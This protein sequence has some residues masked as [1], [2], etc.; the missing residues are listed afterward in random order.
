MSPTSILGLTITSLTEQFRSGR[1]SPVD[2]IQVVLDQIRRMEPQIGAFVVRANEDDLLRQA[3]QAAARWAAGIP[4]GPLDGVPMVIKDAIL[5]KGWPNRL[6]SRVTSAAV[7]EEDAPAVA[8]AREAGALFLGKTTTPEFG[9]KGVTDSPLSGIT[10]NPWDPRLTP[11]GSSGGAA[12]AVAA[13]MGYGA[14]GTDAA[15]SVRIPAAFTGL[16]GLKATRGRIAAYP[17]S[18]LWTL[19]HIGP[20]TR[21]TRDAALMLRVMGRA[22]ARDWNSLPDEEVDYP[23][24]LG[25]SPV[26]G[27]KIAYSP[28]LGHAR[29]DTH[30]AAAVRRVA[31]TLADMGAQVSEVDTPLPD[32]R[33]HFRVYFA[34]GLCHSL[35][36][37]NKAERQR[38]DP[39]LLAL[40]ERHASDTR[41]QFLQAYDFQIRL[42]REA[43]LFHT[44]YDFLLTPTM[45]TPPFQAG[46]AAPEGYDE[47]NWLDWSPFTYPFNLTGQPAL[48]LPCGQTPEG[49]PLAAQFVGALYDDARLLA[50]AHAVEQAQWRQPSLA[51]CLH[52]L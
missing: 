42:A 36:L 15:G 12:A 25:R 37:L 51:P 46:A 41:E 16:V 44:R 14:I 26:V 52:S 5:C 27:L 13:G 40:L 30:V 18:A 22:D 28:T 21:D 17:P 50:L 34:A 45:A 10:R 38:L 23:E 33:K 31:D 35:R 43:R 24:R 1:L 48:S 6:G 7:N 20:I 49:L 11:G 19:G 47:D 29:V 3:G 8:R 2:C 4:A 9:W 39:G 32:A